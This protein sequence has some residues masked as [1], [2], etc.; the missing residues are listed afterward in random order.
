MV[1]ALM[2]HARCRACCTGLRAG[3]GNPAAGGE[4]ARSNLVE[5]KCSPGM[6]VGELCGAEVTVRGRESARAFL[7]VMLPRSGGDLV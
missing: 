2:L 4:T 5:A 7:D 3:N 1:V 6:F